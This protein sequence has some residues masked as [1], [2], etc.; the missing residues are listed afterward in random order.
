MKTAA[1]GSLVLDDGA[2]VAVIGGGPTGSFFSIFALKMAKMIGKELSVTVFDP[3]HFAEDGPKGCNR[4]G[5]IIS[6]LLVQMLAVEGINLPDSV[7]QKGISS[8]NLHTNCGS[9]HIETPSAERTIATVYRG[10]GPKGIIGQEKE[11]FDN[12]LL[13]QAVEEGAVHTSAK[14]DRIDYKGAAPILYSGD[15]EV[16]RADLVVG[17]FGVNSSS[18]KLFEDMEF[19]YAQPAMVTAAI[20]EIGL[21]REALA[22]H[23]GNSIHLFLLPIK[24]MK[25]AAMIPKGTYVTVCILGK[26]VTANTINGF[27]EHPVVKAV[28]PES[29]PYKLNC[30]CSPK[31]NVSAPKRPFA[32]RVVACGDAGS[33]RL[34][35]DGLGAA[36]IMGKA[37]AKTAVFQGVAAEDFRRDYYPVYK[38]IITDNIYG[39][40]LY[41][42]TDFFRKYDLLS[43]AMLEVVRKEQAGAAK[44]RRLS[45]ILW[46]MFTGNE[47]YRNIFPRALSA[48]MNVDLV[49]E[50]VKGLVRR[51]K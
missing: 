15:S 37:A 18:T 42:V 48:R 9:V 1:G 39:H 19:G 26:N 50:S 24:D 40:L 29:I 21:D 35:K 20:A 22:E 12:F 16:C 33:T 11:S 8:Y 31:M 23:F 5:G 49:F 25:F 32:D 17:A 46:D 41:F 7:V 34:F 2:H 36:Y 28:L 14:I 43:T 47:R 38:S 30:R 45:S 4:C 3:K 13:S 44:D 51:D 10:G 27:L 6:E